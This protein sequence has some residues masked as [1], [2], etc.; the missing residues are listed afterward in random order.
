MGL[1][2]HQFTPRQLQYAVAI[3]ET[4]NFRRAASRCHVSQ[5]SL[6]A[7]IGQLESTLGIRLFERDRRQ[8]LL[9][10]AGQELVE[11]AR[12]VLFEMTDLS[13]TAVRLGD[14]LHGRL[15]IGVLPTISP[16]FLPSAVPTLRRRFPQLALQWIE[17]KTETL[18]PLV[19]A[20]SLDAAV[21]AL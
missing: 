17:E 20:G 11:H 18:V 14:P 13:E 4:R 6:S 5:P 15:R 9:T 1:T 3:A 10:A 16:Y 21:L 7:Q 12:R 8:V 19:Q 2:P